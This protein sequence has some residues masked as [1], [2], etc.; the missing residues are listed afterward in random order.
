MS[1]AVSKDKLKYEDNLSIS[2]R[3]QNIPNKKTNASQNSKIRSQS[4]W[5]K[6]SKLSLR[7]ILVRKNKTLNK[8][9]N[10]KREVDNLCNSTNE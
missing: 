8:K 7:I 6:R 2:N 4:K 3:K 9:S 10:K 1:S 5:K